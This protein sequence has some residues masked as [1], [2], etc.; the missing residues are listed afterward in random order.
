MTLSSS[1]TLPLS[2]LD[3]RSDA[4]RDGRRTAILMMLAVMAGYT[5]TDS[6]A[7]YLAPHIPLL[8]IVWARYLGATLLALVLANPIARPEI[9]HSQRL[10][11][12]LIRSMLLLASTFLS[13]ISVRYLQLAQTTAIF[14][15]LPL[16]IALASGPILGE[17]VGPRRYAAIL[18]GFFGVLIVVQ[19][20]SGAVHPAML[21]CVV[22]VVVTAGYNMLTRVLAQRDRAMTTLIYTTAGGAVLLSPVIAFIWV[23]PESA[24]VWLVMALIGLTGACSHGL[25]IAAHARAP[26]SILAPFVYTQ[27]IWAIVSGFL[28]FG[29]IPGLATLTGGGI[30]ISSGLYLWYRE[31]DKRMA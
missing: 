2:S 24:T 4:E 14:F 9:L 22:N 29:D 10:G 20:W 28:V 21:L 30:V 7:K 19:P 31:R 3:A 5:G 18:I 15:A 12:Q 27:L 1:P 13:F 26:A 25:L 17:W 8:Q 6:M 11:L 23:Q 16:T